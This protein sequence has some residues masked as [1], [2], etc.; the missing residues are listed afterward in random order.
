MAAITRIAGAAATGI[1]ARIHAVDTTAA[2]RLGE[3]TIGRHITAREDTT[4]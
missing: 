1:Q 4:R 3:V 2:S